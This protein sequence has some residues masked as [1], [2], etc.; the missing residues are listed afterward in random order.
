MFARISSID[1]AAIGFLQAFEKQIFALKRAA[2]GTVQR[3]LD[4]LGQAEQERVRQTD[5]VRRASC[6]S[7]S[8][9]FSISLR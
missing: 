7:H 4:R 8:I 3:F 9:S 5:D 2:D 6:F 1:F